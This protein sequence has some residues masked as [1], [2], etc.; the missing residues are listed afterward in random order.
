MKRKFLPL[1]VLS[2]GAGLTALI[3]GLL[4]ALAGRD[5]KGLLVPT[6]PLALLL[7][8]LTAAA[9]AVILFQ[10]RTAGK[11]RRYSSNFPPSNAAATGCFVMAAGIALTLIL[12]RAEGLR[13]GLPRAV[14]GLLAVPALVRTGLC[15]RSGKRPFFLLP[16]VVCLF[17]T[18]HTVSRYQSWSSQPQ[19][20]NFFFPMMSCILM[21]VFSYSH[22]AFPVGLGSRRVLLASGLLGGFF[23][24][25]AVSGL[26]D[27]FLHA[28]AAVWMLTNLCSLTPPPRRGE[29]PASEG[30]PV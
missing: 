26:Q 8:L 20:L 2:A 1:P 14:A 29:A 15:R 27:L 11:S 25:T 19:L 16:A 23:A 4:L 18:L 12:T 3:L 22:T 13:M 7:W 9:A 30:A 28:A 24:L 5:E 17:L 10:V 21:M 6:H